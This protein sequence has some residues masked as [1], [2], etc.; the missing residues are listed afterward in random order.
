M[1]VCACVCESF[2]CSQLH[3]QRKAIAELFALPTCLHVFLNLKNEF[4]FLP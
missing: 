4:R 1:C 2:N 3:P